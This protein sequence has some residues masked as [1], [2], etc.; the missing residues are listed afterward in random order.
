MGHLKRTI[1]YVNQGGG[2]LF[3]TASGHLSTGCPCR[4]NGV[5][6]TINFPGDGQDCF[7]VSRTITDA[8]FIW[9]GGRGLPGPQF[10]CGLKRNCGLFLF[11][12]WVPAPWGQRGLQFAVYYGAYAPNMHRDYPKGQVG[13]MFYLPGEP[14]YP[15]YSYWESPVYGGDQVVP[16]DM[17]CIKDPS[18]L[19]SRFS[20]TVS[21][22]VAR[23]LGGGYPYPDMQP[24]AD[25]IV[26]LS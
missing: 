23:Y 17:P 4:P 13:I 9:Y 6:A 21:V 3:K 12:G 15:C 1:K 16:V 22:P 19:G 26:T 20:G 2:G 7:A 25:L 24:C 14:S 11:S 10:D 5:T 8:E 18:R